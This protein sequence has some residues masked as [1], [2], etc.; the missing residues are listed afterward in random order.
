MNSIDSILNRITMYRL[1]LYYLLALVGYAMLATLWGGMHYSPLA[2]IFS[3]VLIIAV[4]WVSNEAFAYIFHAHKSIES[5]YITA[6]IL[7]LI[8]TPVMPTDIIGAVALVLAS[9]L[10]MGSKY[11]LTIHN[12]HIFNPAAIAVVITGG[13]MGVYASWW[14]GS[15]T[16]LPVALI[17]GLLIARKIRKFDLVFTFVIVA[18]V[19]T[20]L[21]GNGAVALLSLK[22]LFVDS[23]LFFFALVMLT[24]PATTPVTPWQQIAYAAVVGVLYAPAI[25]IG[26]IYSTPEIALVVGNVFSYIVS[27]KSRFMLTLNSVVETSPTTLEFIFKPDRTIRFKPGQYLE[28]TLPHVHSDSRGNRRYFTIASS[29]TDTSVR[30]GVKFYEPASSFKTALLRMKLGEQLSVSQKAGDFILPKNND[31]KLVFIAGGIGITPFVSQVRY[32]LDTGKAPT[33]TILYSNRTVADIAYR[34]LLE[35]A[36]ARFG[37]NTVYAVGSTSADAPPNTIVGTIDAA[38][39]KREIP[40]YAERIFYV[41]GPH[42]MVVSFEQQLRALGVPHSNIKVDFFPGFV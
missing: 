19:T 38:L 31:T 27:P 17:G 13:I 39:I 18:A 21:T 35:T 33:T 14:V 24:E 41:S 1:V 34:E 6:L 22:Q 11:I 2:I 9:L 10:A 23:A 28:W 42:A 36:R 7:S 3:S 25:H 20:I 37:I 4:C 30:L 8:M 12:T 26:T 16:L 5:V 32:F 40:D 15:A 29:P